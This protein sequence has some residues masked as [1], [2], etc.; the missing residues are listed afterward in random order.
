MMTNNPVV[1]L[2]LDLYF[3]LTVFDNYFDNKILLVS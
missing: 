3:E 2:Y 1:A